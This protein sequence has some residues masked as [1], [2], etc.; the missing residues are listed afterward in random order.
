MLS[1]LL[2]SAANRYQ[3][4]VEEIQRP[5]HARS[6]ADPRRSVVSLAYS[7]FDMKGAWLAQRF[8]FSTHSNVVHCYLKAKDLFHAD[9][10]SRKRIREMAA[11]VGISEEDLIRA[12]SGSKRTL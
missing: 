7:V 3:V 12:M 6:C 10:L 2:I 11:D 4:P 8:K 5:T 9:Q 1:L